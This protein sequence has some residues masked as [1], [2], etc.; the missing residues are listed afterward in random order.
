MKIT[1]VECIPVSIKFAKPMVMSGGAATGAD[2]VVVKINTDEGVTGVSE[3]GDTSM[4][5][6][7]ESQDS[8]MFNIT[9][10]F[11]PQ[12]LLGEDPFNVEKIVARM[13]KVVKVNNQSKAVIDYALHDVMGRALGV[14]VY[15]LLGGLSNE[16]I[17]LGFVMSSGTPDEVKAEGRSLVKTG[18]RCLKL[19]VGSRTPEEDAEIIAALRQEVGAGIKIMIDANGGWHYHQALRCLKMVAEYDIFVAEQPVPWWDIEGLA[20]LRRKVEMPVFADEAAAELNDLIKLIQADAVDGFFLKVPKAGGILKSRK[21]V[22]IAQSVGLSVM[23]GCMINSGIG[24]AVEAHFLAATEWMGR[25]EQEAIGPLNLHNL[26]D[27]VTNP[28]KNDLAVNVPRYE[29]GFLYPPEGPG[30]GVEL[31]EAAVRQFATPGK[32]PV[33]IGK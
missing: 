21:W 23:C 33:V 17:P 6:M 18:F 27:T 16:K 14:P 22:A 26:P 3:T 24:A 9:K 25:I 1:G 7:G 19:K 8:I 5:Y 30:F 13:D 32:S 29:G 28:P 11:A 15:K 31:N 4:W 2:A 20:R 12:I 10:I